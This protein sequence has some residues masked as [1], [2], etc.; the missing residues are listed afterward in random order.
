MSLAIAV[1]S[2]VLFFALGAVWFVPRLASPAAAAWTVTVTVGASTLASLVL[3]LQVV[4]AGFSEIPFVADAIGW[5]RALYAGQHGASPLTGGIALS[6][7]VAICWRVCS[8]AGAT[9]ASTRRF[10]GVAGIVI[11]ESDRPVAFA[12]P[13][14]PGGVVIS[15]AMVDALDREQRAAVLAHESAH[16]RYHHHLFVHF[17]HA[18][19]AGLPFLVPLARK[20][21]FLTERWADEQAALRVGS[22]RLVAD[23]IAKVA[24]LPSAG[25][26]THAQ[27][28]AGGDVIGRFLAL[29]SPPPPRRCYAPVVIA[30]F[31]CAVLTASTFQFQN[32]LVF[33]SHTN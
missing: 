28:L 30:T 12:V 23:T 31:V 9:R 6:L 24:L 5:C 11:V 13:G 25:V 32:L 27:S 10:S 18:C 7:L 2:L 3:L 29:E 22:R 14:N 16:L 33:F 21:T 8:Y 15:R 20:V 4:A 26:P 17:A 19:A 1:P